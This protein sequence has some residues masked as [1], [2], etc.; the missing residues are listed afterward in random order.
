V[1]LL[2]SSVFKVR[3]CFSSA[4]FLLNR[5]DYLMCLR[6]VAGTLYVVNSDNFNFVDSVN[7]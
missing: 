4:V 7:S 1:K 5:L 3:K 2:L 6:F